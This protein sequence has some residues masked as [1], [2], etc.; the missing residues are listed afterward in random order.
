MNKI[1]KY[2]LAIIQLISKVMLSLQN[3]NE[4]VTLN[5]FVVK[6]DQVGVS[7]L[8]RLYVCVL[9]IYTKGQNNGQFLMTFV[10]SIKNKGSNKAF[11]KLVSFFALFNKKL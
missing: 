7:S 9:N 11:I 3:T 10:C 6:A 8:A 1:F 2:D 5:S 4:S